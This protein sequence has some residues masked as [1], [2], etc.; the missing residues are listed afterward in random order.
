MPD[1][2]PEPV[3]PRTPHARAA[4]LSRYVGALTLL[5]VG[6]DHIEQYYVDS[7][8]FI[9]T[10]G[11]LFALNFIAATIVGLGLVAGLHRVWGQWGTRL[12]TLLALSGIGIAAS[13]LAGLLLSERG[14]GLFGFTE[15]GYRTPVVV[16]IVLE[17]AATLSLAANLVLTQR[18]STTLA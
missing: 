13:S 16:S 18:L 6:A 14:S 8:R 1:I 9:P 3:V 11:T 4:S 15:I 10:I 2:G 17:L 7:Y 5:G 12:V